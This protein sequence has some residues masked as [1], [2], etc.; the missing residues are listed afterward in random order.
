LINQIRGFLQEYGIVIAQG[1][2]RLRDAIPELLEDAENGL[3]DAA[4]QVISLLAEEWRYLDESIV[5][6]EKSIKAQAKSSEAATRLMKIKGVGEKIS[7]AAVAIIGDGKGLKNGRHCAANLGVVP[8]EHSSG[9]KQNL[10]GITKRGNR[11]LRYLLIQGAWSIIRH[12][13]KS[14]DRITRWARGVIERR[15]KQKAAVAIAN[16]LARIIWSMLRYN[17]EYQPA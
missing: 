1:K 11:Y 4:R 15:G 10:G 5:E 13:D 16:K 9:G 17:T 8:K 7:T 3:T 14:N 6:L 12:I 2:Q